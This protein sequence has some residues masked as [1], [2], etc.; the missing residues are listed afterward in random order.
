MSER[1]TDKECDFY[2]AKCKKSPYRLFRRQ[3]K[4]GSDV[5]ENLIWPAESGVAPPENMSN[6]VCP[7][8]KTALVRK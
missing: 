6:L 7:K 1:K 8:C 2:C 4:P 3:V 5:F